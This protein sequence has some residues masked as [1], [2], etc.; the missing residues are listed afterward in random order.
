M[1]TFKEE[2]GKGYV[3][4]LSNESMPGLLK[5]GC[6]KNDPMSRAVQLHTTGVPTPFKLEFALFSEDAQESEKMAHWLLSNKKVANREFFNVCK[7]EAMG[8]VF[9]SVYEG[10]FI[11]DE[12]NIHEIDLDHY[13]SLAK[14]FPANIRRLLTH[15][16]PSEWVILMKR[17]SEKERA[18]K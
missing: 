18:S 1:N 12:S 14:T 10:L 11:A 4:V 13:A 6:T 8:A 9:E 15:I 2:K 17:L 7:R 5:I 3:Y 16:K